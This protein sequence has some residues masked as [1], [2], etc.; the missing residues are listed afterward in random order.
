MLGELLFVS[1]ERVDLQWCAKEGARGMPK[2]IAGDVMMLKRV[3]SY[4]ANDVGDAARQ[5][6][7]FLLMLVPIGSDWASDSADRRITS[8]G[9]IYLC[10]SLVSAWSRTHATLA[11]SGT[12]AESY[13]LGSRACET[14]ARRSLLADLGAACDIMLQSDSVAGIW[15]QFCVGLG[16]MRHTKTKYLFFPQLFREKVRRIEKITTEENPA[17]TG[18]MYFNDTTLMNH[19]SGS[20]VLFGV[21]C[22]EGSQVKAISGA[23]AMSN[24][25]AF[26]MWRAA[27]IA[28]TQTHGGGSVGVGVGD[29]H[30]AEMHRPISPCLGESGRSCRGHRPLDGAAPRSR[31]LPRHAHVGGDPAR[32]RSMPRYRR[33][34]S[35]AS[36]QYVT[37]SRVA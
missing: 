12:E 25:G 6:S 1:H 23:S 17:G 7:D 32:Q 29:L 15:S 33:E 5:A 35:Q 9:Q 14:L 11:L 13:A 4:T 18:A 3:A 8:P 26:S 19:R 22:R 10:G 37:P 30:R 20:G 31:A 21:P 36:L 2:P 24:Q 34:Q 28:S 16:R 27:M